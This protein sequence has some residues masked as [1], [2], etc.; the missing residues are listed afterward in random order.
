MVKIK[1]TLGVDTDQDVLASMVGDS[2]PEVRWGLASKTANQDVLASM[3]GDVDVP[4]RPPV[5]TGGTD[6]S[7]QIVRQLLSGDISGQPTLVRMLTDKCSLVR[8]LAFDRLEDQTIE[9][10]VDCEDPE[11][12]RMLP[13]GTTNQ[14]ILA[15]LLN[16]SDGIVRNSARDRMRYLAEQD[17]DDEFDDYY[18]GEF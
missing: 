8:W 13:H 7:R 1:H 10:L 11:V 3:V 14:A 4:I 12:R 9:N 6:A 17:N 15:Y 18:P 2:D 16:D 5:R